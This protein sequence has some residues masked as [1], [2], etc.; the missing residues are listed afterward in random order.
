MTTIIGRQ[1]QV[2]EQDPPTWEPLHRIPGFTATLLPDFMCMFAI[3][4]PGGRRLI[5]YKHRQ[6]LRYMYV[7]GQTGETFL[8]RAG[9]YE[10]V[11]RRE[12]WDYVLVDAR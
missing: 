11:G 2:T 8:Y 3:L 5:A 6:T 7:D 9:N 1:C 4:A 10:L 12:A